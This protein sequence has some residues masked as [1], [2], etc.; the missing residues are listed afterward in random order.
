MLVCLVRK[1]FL[2]FAH[3]LQVVSKIRKGSRVNVITVVEEGLES[4]L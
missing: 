1:A 3:Q 4:I 2:F